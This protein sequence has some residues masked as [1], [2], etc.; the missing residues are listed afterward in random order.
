MSRAVHNATVKKHKDQNSVL[1]S[2][3]RTNETRNFSATL[4]SE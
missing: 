2:E 1:R 3:E 4:G